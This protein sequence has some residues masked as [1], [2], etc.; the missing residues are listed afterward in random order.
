MEL[1][2]FEMHSH[3][4]MSQTLEIS[5]ILILG[6]FKTQLKKQNVNFEFPRFY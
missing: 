4:L 2:A 1:I 5:D 6:K 3:V